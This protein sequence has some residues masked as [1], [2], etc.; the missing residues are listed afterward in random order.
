[1]SD[2]ES[3]ISIGGVGLNELQSAHRQHPELV[4]WSRISHV[5]IRDYV[6]TNAALSLQLREAAEREAQLEAHVSVVESE[7]AQLAGELE[8]EK[9]QADDPLEGPE[10]I[11]AMARGGA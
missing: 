6:E 10:A 2:G 3:T 1:M 9:Q 4:S 11:S 8:P 7:N 5:V